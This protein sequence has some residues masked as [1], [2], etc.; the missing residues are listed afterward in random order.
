MQGL[1]AGASGESA[2]TGTAKSGSAAL[3]RVA[4]TS[5]P[6]ALAGT[7]G[8]TLTGATGSGSAGCGLVALLFTEKILNLFATGAFVVAEFAVAVFI[9]LF[10]EQFADIGWA[11]GASLCLGIGGGQ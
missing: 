9:E 7:A 11:T 5:A 2:L 8:T 10:E 3:P 6:A 4:G 1:S